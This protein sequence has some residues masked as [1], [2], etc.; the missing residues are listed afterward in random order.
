MNSQSTGISPGSLKHLIVIEQSTAGR[1]TSGSIT[2]A[3]SPF[4]TVRGSISS[5]GGREFYQ[6][7][8]VNAALTHEVILRWLPGVVPSMRVRYDDPKTG[9]ARYFDIKS[10]ANDSETRRF[11]RLMTTELVGVQP[12][13]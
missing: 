12:Q 1:G 9:V 5:S 10:V 7:R 8:L 3:W 13:T 11:L 4:A 2:K 6:S